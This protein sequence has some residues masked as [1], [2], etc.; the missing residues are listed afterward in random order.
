MQVHRWEHGTKATRKPNS[1]VRIRSPASLGE[2]LARIHLKAGIVQIHGL[3]PLPDLGK[4]T[5]GDFDHPR[6]TFVPMWYHK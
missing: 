3:G 1:I 2:H 4:D 6:R 5:S